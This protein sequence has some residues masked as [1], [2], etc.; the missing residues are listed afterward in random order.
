MFVL[1]Y[2][3]SEISLL[4]PLTD[5]HCFIYQRF[6]IVVF[7]LSLFSAYFV[8]WL[9]VFT[10]FYQNELTKDSIGKGWQILNFSALP[11]LIVMLGTNLAIFLT[12][13]SYRVGPCGCMPV[14]S[15]ES[16]LFKWVVLMI[17][18]T[19][20]QI[21]LLLSFIYP[22]C[23]HKKKLLSRGL[24]HKPIIAV[25][26]RA[27]IVAGVCILSDAL[28]TTFAVLYQVNTVYIT[29]IVFSLN[30]IIN[31]MGVFFSFKTWKDMMFPFRK[32]FERSTTILH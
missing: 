19:T 6:R 10:V 28:N 25:V 2:V 20:F 27:A 26:Q 32:E 8:L 4:A 31:L 17:W 16:A 29:H 22:L 15:T 12:T 7:A 24:D 18:T 11:L 9:R 21:I 23:K 5:I 13:P 3:G 14:Q 30:L 1:L